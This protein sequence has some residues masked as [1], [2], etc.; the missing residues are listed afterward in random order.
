MRTVSKSAIEAAI[1]AWAPGVIITSLSVKE[2][3]GWAFTSFVLEEDEPDGRV[4]VQEWEAKFFP[5]GVGGWRLTEPE[6]QSE[7]FWS[8]DDCH[9][10]GGPSRL[11]VA[12]QNCC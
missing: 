8:W 10:C 9:V 7:R 3:K 11:G 4:R 5:T 6:L 2:Y 12:C 1:H